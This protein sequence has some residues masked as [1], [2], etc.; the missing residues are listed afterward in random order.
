[1]AAPTPAQ[2]PTAPAGPD[3]E[4]LSSSVRGLWRA[5]SPIEQRATTGYDVARVVL[6]SRAHESYGGGRGPGVEV[7]D[8][9]S[10]TSLRSLGE[11]VADVRSLFL[12]QKRAELDGRKLVFGL[13]LLDPALRER[14]AP[15]DFLKTL[16]EEIDLHANLSKRGKAL[17]LPDAVPTLSDQ[18]SE[19]DRLGRKAFAEALGSRLH[20]EYQRSKNELGRAESF[21]L[22]LEGP[23]GS[24]KTSLL[25]F[26]GHDL[27]AR[28]P[29][30]LVV[31]FNAW[32]HQ[33]AGAPWWLLMAAVQREGLHDWRRPD[34]MV[35]L[36]AG[37][38]L[39][40][41]WLAKF[42]LLALAVGI[43]LLSVLI[44]T[45]GE[46]GGSD[47][48]TLAGTIGSIVGVIVSTA[49]LVHSF[50]GTNARGAETFVQQTRDPMK[51]LE[52]RFNRIVRTIGRPIAVFIDDLD[53]CRSDHVV[54]LLEGIQTLLRDAPVTFVVAADRHWLYESYAQ[55]YEKHQRDDPG[56]PLGHLFLEKTFQLSTSLP[57]LSKRERDEYWDALIFPREEDR[58][59]IADLERR[60]AAEFAGASSE[61]EVMARLDGPPDAN[62][63]E[64]RLRREAAV[65]RLGAP[66][67]LRHTEHTLSRFAGLLEPNP[68]A[69]KRLVNAYGVERAVQILEGHSRELVNP[70]EKLA[71]WTIVRS[72]WPLL[73]E[74]LSDKPELV[75]ELEKTG[76]PAEVEAEKDRPYLARL[77][78]DE[79]VQR[80]VRGDGLEG[81]RLDEEAIRFFVSGPPEE[82]P[83][84]HG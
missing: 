52:R 4:D 10:G 29:R 16:G 76:V 67:L 46:L 72:R 84:V 42:W 13:A 74:Y 36:G 9:P 40:R 18:P 14:L 61:P 55:V 58:R 44:V 59:R 31:E 33:R 77:F 70:R 17:Y 47:I 66:E 2:A 41:L 62:W 51:R 50:A 83:V 65:R 24:G 57:R 23:W 11:L 63:L 30:W 82:L 69:M 43:T 73:A 75:D 71:L 54:D 35:R 25:R 15:H 38:L 27:R 3:D 34:R 81:V 68:R 20:D 78:E 32:Q 37:A 6:A 22:H 28:K 12:P 26:L 60:I 56:R 49:G 1:M 53:R 19:V 45:G 7:G 5:T 21:M 79:E 8:T 39:W 64:Q 80:V 48:G